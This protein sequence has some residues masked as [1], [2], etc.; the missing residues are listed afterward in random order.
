MVERMAFEEPRAAR[1]WRDEQPALLE[2][3]EE[4]AAVDAAIAGAQGRAGRLVVIEGPAG[5]GKTS[6]L[7]EGR[8]R[9]A[10]SGLTV[11]YA[12][13]SEL[14][15]AFSFGVVRQLFEA[16]VATA[17]PEE[18]SRL[19]GGAAVQAARLFRPGDSSEG[20]EEDVYALLHGLYWLTLNLAES[21][22]LA[23][24]VDDL[25][26]SD[27]PSMRWLGYMARRLEGV[28]V[29]VLATL[30]PIEDEH[31]LV[32]EL[33]ADPET[34][35]VRPNALSAP[36]VAE[37]VRQELGADA[38]DLFCLACHHATGG[39]PLLLRELLR[40]L[41]AEGVGPVAA[42]LPVVERLAPDAVTRSVRLRLGR[43][44]AEAARLA[45]VV[46]VLGDRA[47]REQAAALA[48][49]ERRQ[50]APVAAALA[51]VDL[52]RPEPPFS[53]VHPLVRNAVY[54]SIPNQEREA[55]HA[56]AAELLAEL[57]APPEQVAAQLLLAPPES[58]PCAV[59]L[60]REAARRATADAGLESAV[61]YLTRALEEP[62]EDEERGELLLELA[63]VEANVG[64]P[65]VVAHLRD[66]ASLLREPDRQA[67]A[68][69]ALGHA[70]YWAGDEEEGVE[71]L[72]RALAEHPDLD[73][74]L[75]HRLEAELVVNA[76]RLASQYER[77]RERLAR[78]DVSLD[79]GPGARVL[80]AGRAY[81]ACAGG[82]DAERAAA[83]ALAALTAMSDEERARNYT[84][85]AYALLH[86]D[87]LEEGV[88]LLD[89]TLADVR[90]RGAV[91]HFS[92]LSMTRAI[93]Q[94]AR[95]ALVEAEA[96]GRAA[97]EALPRRDVWF[98]A[99]AHGWLAQILVERGALAEAAG[100]LEAVE[101]TVAPD[102][103]SRAPLLRAGAMVEAAGGDHRAALAR[104]LELG[105][106]LAAFGHTN[107]PASYPASRSLAALEYHALGETGEALSLAR[108]EVELAR[109]WGAP[110]T[111]G[112]ALR[113]L[114][115]I[116]GGEA[117]IGLSREAVA[118]LQ[119]SPARL[120]HAYALADLGAALR[121]ANHRAEAREHL[122]QAL[123]LAQRSGATLL[124]ER[125]HEELIATGARPRRIVQTGAAALTPSERRIAA[126]AAEGLSNREIAQAL[127]VMLRTVEMHLSNAFRKLGVSSRTQLPAALA[128][129]EAP[130][131]AGA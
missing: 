73:L 23:L 66:A 30:R 51:R 22:P 6:L 12:R 39:N 109:A 31:P 100:L 124:A 18:Q 55:E 44:P 122:R 46:A 67:E 95:G 82:G 96:D 36:S 99:A 70:L 64:A 34:A 8:A 79:E 4:L 115:L 88:H 57:G 116:Q 16:A 107:P 62:L 94:Y 105:R 56:R 32:A 10:A 75:R 90:R 92:S 68:L 25:Q 37:L 119:P 21:R 19:L 2:R 123:E 114:G 112:R 54:E 103:F 111:L 17:S 121:R 78:V 117:G 84:G 43:L 45:R 129:S 85:G 113:I 131:A 108:E 14:E 65:N 15:A 24:A 42:S 20:G 77:A 110:R 81:H 59:T 48:E 91:F 126:M 104:A 93:F 38:E 125:A 76:T 13:G 106:S 71:V 63:G 41:A 28:P 3:A 83:T 128:E 26:W 49:L 80:L 118:V 9:A 58:V 98:R 86:T 60:L 35:I 7:A 120:E 72:E 74:E 47:E 89:A 5:I 11:L 1:P 102:A 97:L 33:L 27:P 50:I 53:F 127:F 130:V 40:T 87:R 29:C 52:L 101:P 69:L 61:R